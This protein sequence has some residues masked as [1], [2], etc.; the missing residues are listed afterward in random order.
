[1]PQG[2]KLHRFL[3]AALHVANARI[4]L[5]IDEEQG[6][7]C[8]FGSRAPEILEITTSPLDVLRF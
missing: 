3:P 4:Q 8:C 2:P 6:S 1:M 5:G 7:Q